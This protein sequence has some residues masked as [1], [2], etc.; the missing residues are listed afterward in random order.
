MN[1]KSLLIGS[2]AA[3][4][5]VTGARAADAVM[6]PEPEPVEYVRVCDAHG[7]GFFY[8]PGTETCLQ[9]SGYVWYQIG[10][11]SYRD[12][13][14][15]FGYQ[16][17]GHS[18]GEGW[19]KSVRA[20]VNFDARSET[21][22]GTLRSYIRLQASWNGAGDGPV[23]ADQA[24]IMLGGFMAGY[25]ESFWVDSKNGGPSNYGSHSWSGMSYGYSQRALIGYR[26]DSNG[27]FGALSL[28]DDTLTGE[29]Y[30][31]DVVAKLGY[32]AGWGAV[33]AKVA[34]DESL[35]SFAAQVGSDQR[36]EH[37]RL[38]AARDRLLL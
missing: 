13:G 36:S 11:N 29:G 6:A 30:M 32:S 17:Q 23:A 28:E 15:T 19:F 9:I 4:V 2:A 38:V 24:Y 31:P 18:S 14:D 34:Y 25:S 12:P 1:I 22:W 8:I 21:E 33:W 20:R 26:F 10:A 5:A 7:N 35:E 37:A 27:F 16:G 3:L